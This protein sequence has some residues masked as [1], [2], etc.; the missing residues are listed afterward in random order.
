MGEQKHRKDFEPEENVGADA[1]SLGLDQCMKGQAKRKTK[2]NK[3]KHKNVRQE[4][5]P[6]LIGTHQF[7]SEGG[8]SDLVHLTGIVRTQIS[9]LHRL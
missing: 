9:I 2:T 3:K 5:E 8:G 1:L 4:D 6:E 7:P